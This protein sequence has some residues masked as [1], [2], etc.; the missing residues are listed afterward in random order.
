MITKL[1]SGKFEVVVALIKKWKEVKKLDKQLWRVAWN[2]FF[3]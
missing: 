3:I 1:L 2:M